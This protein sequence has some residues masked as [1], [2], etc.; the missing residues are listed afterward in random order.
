MNMTDLTPQTAA[1]LG[2]FCK[3]LTPEQQADTLL[4]ALSPKQLSEVDAW[5]SAL[6]DDLERQLEDEAVAAWWAEEDRRAQ[7]GLPSQADYL[8]Q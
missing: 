4:G 1:A 5:L 6:E 7:F 3:G 2:E 8:P